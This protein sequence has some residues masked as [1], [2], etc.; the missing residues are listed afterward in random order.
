MEK[1]QTSRGEDHWR[2]GTNSARPLADL[3]LARTVQG[4]LL[5][6]GLRNARAKALIMRA[7]S[8]RT[9]A[10]ET[11]GACLISP[12]R[13]ICVQAAR[14]LSGLNWT[15]MTQ[16]FWH[17]TVIRTYSS[18]FL[19]GHRIFRFGLILGSVH[20]DTDCVKMLSSITTRCSGI[21]ARVPSLP[22][23]PRTLFSG[24]SEDRKRESG[25]NRAYQNGCY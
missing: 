19:E 7:S 2:F 12:A 17:T 5:S 15:T 22:P 3:S 14:L 8:R 9:R 4:R 23:H 16:P 20:H 18:H 6:R 10:R 11:D 25:G 21:W 13:V 24:R 1:F